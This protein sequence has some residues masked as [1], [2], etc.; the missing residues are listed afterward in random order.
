MSQTTLGSQATPKSYEVELR[1]AVDVANI[2]TLL[3]V[4][5]QM[6]GDLSWLK[7][8]FKPSTNKGLGDNPDGGLNSGLQKQIRN[9]AYE[10]ILLWHKGKSIIL[11]TPSNQQLAEMLGVAMGESVPVG[12]ADMIR[13]ELDLEATSNSPEVGSGAGKKNKPPNGFTA[14][15][16]GAGASGLCAAANLQKLKIPY[17]IIERNSEIG[18]VWFENHYPGAG[19]DTP[20]HLYS[21]SFA[22]NDWSRYFAPQKEL[23]EYFNRVADDFDIRKDVQFET[24][25]TNAIYDEDAQEWILQVKRGSNESEQIRA[26]LVISAV[27]AFNKP[28]WPSIKGLDTFKGPMPHTA[29]WQDEVQLENKKVAIIGNGASAMQ[30]VPAIVDK[31]ERLT[32]FQRSPQWAAPFEQFKKEI[33]EAVRWLFLNVPLYAKWYRI[34]LAWIFNDRIYDSLQKDRQWEHPERSINATNDAHRSYFKRH[35]EAEIGDRRDLLEK[36]LP[37]Y[38]PFGKRMLL[39]NGWFKAMTR[40]NVDLVTD[41][42]TEIREDRILTNDGFEYEV[43]VLII[44]T[45]FDV[46]QFLAPMHVVGRAGKLLED[47]WAGDNARAYLGTA[48]PGFPNFFCLYGPNTQFGHGGSLIFML[49]LQMRYLMGIFEQMFSRAISSIECRQDVHDDYNERVDNAHNNMVWTH[50]GMD[51]Y[52]RNSRGR[53]V[54]NNPFKIVDYWHLVQNADLDD[55]IIKK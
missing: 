14:V 21:F 32:V 41:S 54:V 49:E 53:V 4:I 30:L 18:G 28:K 34:R 24:E 47:E 7:D 22:K 15:I 36:V 25:V 19:V 1:A 46:L 2:P 51:V 44:A 26:N 20:S 52:Y 45:G 33:P 50:P 29:R 43:D 27:G 3:L 6:T 39:D 9:F 10:A 55:Y 12:Y 35:I 17:T 13:H 38:P 5:V 31:V 11:D 48:V 8:P 40:D 37:T 42:I 23:R 16:I